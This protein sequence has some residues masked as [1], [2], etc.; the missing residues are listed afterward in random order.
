MRK[1]IRR[2]NAYADSSL[3]SDTDPYFGGQDIGKFWF[4][5]VIP[6]IDVRGVTKYDN[7]ISD[8]ATLVIKAMISDNSMTADTALQNFIKEVQN[9]APD[10][11]V[12]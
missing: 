4:D 11:T 9:K 2:S 10:I 12:K 7:I 6:K 8:T 1:S 5:E 3:I